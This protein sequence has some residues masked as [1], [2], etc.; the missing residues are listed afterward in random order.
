ML[1]CSVVA[2]T[3]E[4]E[5]GRGEWTGQAILPTPRHDAPRQ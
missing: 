4:A 5:Q 2:Q 1:A 3:A